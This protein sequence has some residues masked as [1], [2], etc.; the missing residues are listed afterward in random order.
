MAT[1]LVNLMGIKARNETSS[2]SLSE[3]NIAARGGSGSEIDS[4]RA[5]FRFHDGRSTSRLRFEISA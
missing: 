1:S 3:Q 5:A 2:Y 4:H